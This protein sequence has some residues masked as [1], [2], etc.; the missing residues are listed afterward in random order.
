[1]EHWI[2]TI[3]EP[4]RL[5]LAWQ[6]PDPKGNRTRF[7][8][9]ELIQ[10]NGDCLL[11]Y[12]PP[13]KLTEACALGF[14]GYPA[15]KR[16][17][18]EHRLGVMATFLRRLPPRSRADFA[19]YKAQF[20]LHTKLDLSDFALLAYTEAKL[21]SD[22]FSIVNPL[23][24]VHGPCQF[25]FEVAGYR[26]YAKTLTS[27]LTLGQP[28]QFVPEPT[29]KYDPNAVRVEAT[30]EVIGYV[31]RLQADAFL[32]WLRDGVVSGCVE[33]LNGNPDKPRAF[34]FVSVLP[35]KSAAAA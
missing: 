34:M 1:V 28:L 15:F 10:E 6:G 14:E 22:G 29:N 16:D 26:H 32:R 30:K 18:L 4:K 8:V 24:D 7:A 19:A 17:Q 25:V 13:E 23:Q 9:G 21:P 35:Q 2:E 3:C 12:F 11:R 5:L 31:N 20:R 33:R 27:P